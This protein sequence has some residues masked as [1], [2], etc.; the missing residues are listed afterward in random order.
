MLMTQL[1]GTVISDI[2]RSRAEIN[3]AR[4][5]VLNAALMVRNTVKRLGART[6]TP[7]HRLTSIKRREP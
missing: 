2:A 5:L 4:L 3:G 1:I 7:G 6:L